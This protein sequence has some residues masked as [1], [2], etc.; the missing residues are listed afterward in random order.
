MT[1]VNLNVLDAV[2]DLSLLNNLCIVNTT[3]VDRPF[4]AD[5]VLT[6]LVDATPFAIE[7]AKAGG[8]TVVNSFDGITFKLAK[9]VPFCANAIALH[10]ATVEGGAS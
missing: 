10:A 8:W 1:T 5:T 4:R 7:G 9:M 2:T 6:V 3:T